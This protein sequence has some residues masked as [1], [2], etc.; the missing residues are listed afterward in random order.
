MTVADPRHVVTIGTA[1]GSAIPLLFDN[2][3]IRQSAATSTTNAGVVK[4][5]L[6]QCRAAGD[7]PI[8]GATR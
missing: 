4:F 6:D 2:E 3:A 8:H 5:D 1:P 7:R